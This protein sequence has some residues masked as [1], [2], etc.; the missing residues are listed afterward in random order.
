MA[1]IFDPLYYRFYDDEGWGF[2]E[3]VVAQADSDY[4]IEAAAYRELS[5]SEVEGNVTPM[6][7]GS[8][9]MDVPFSEE[10]EEEDDRAFSRQEESC[11]GQGKVRGHTREV[12]MILL[13]YVEGTIMLSMNPALLSQQA[14]DNILV[15]AIE[16][17]TNI[18]YCGV[19]HD[20]VSPRNIIICGSDTD[21]ENPALRICYIDFNQ[22][23]VIRIVYD[24]DPLEQY[25][26]PLFSCLREANMW[27]KWG[28][29]TAA[30][31]KEAKGWMWRQWW[32]SEK[33]VEIEEVDGEPMEV[34]AKDIKSHDG[35][36]KA[37]IEENAGI[38]EKVEAGVPGSVHQE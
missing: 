31:E 37:G 6:Y 17:S 23:A 35:I 27:R 9:T 16:A 29:L 19:R 34:E 25:R 26:N 4:S 36:E 10:E 7:Y 3:D 12:R 22:S 15:K 8:W 20:D 2:K 13:E 11:D 21:L 38:E 30:D 24:R 33:Y 18:K 28:W 1:K 5:G 14:R 32:H